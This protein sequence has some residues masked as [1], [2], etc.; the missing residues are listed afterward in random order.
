MLTSQSLPPAPRRR[1]LC[2]ETRSP[3]SGRFLLAFLCLVLLLG[4]WASFAAAGPP[5]DEA[6]GPLLRSFKIIGAKL[7]PKKKLVAEVTMPLPSILPWK[8]PPVFKGDA[9]EGDLVRLQAYY[10]RQG[11]YH[12]EIVP[13]I[14]TTDNQVKVELHITEGPYV[15]VVHEEVAITPATPP[16]DLSA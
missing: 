16:L 10:Q 1:P 12:T 14:E 7:V 3:G 9:L 13:Q 4:P 11:F 2:M 6:A 15:Q 8:R 5:P